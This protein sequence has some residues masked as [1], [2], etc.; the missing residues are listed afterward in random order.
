MKSRVVLAPKMKTNHQANNPMKNAR[1]GA[2]ARRQT[3]HRRLQGRAD[4]LSN[5]AFSE[6]VRRCAA[7]AALMI[8]GLFVGAAGAEAQQEA[9][10][11][12]SVVRQSLD[13]ACWTAPMLPPSPPPF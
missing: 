10:P 8:A 13:D 11:P 12:S 4:L 9:S 2:I 3:M 5:F 6:V 1:I 7:V